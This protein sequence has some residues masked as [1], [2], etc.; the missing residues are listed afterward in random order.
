MN[1][2]SNRLTRITIRFNDSEIIKLE[3]LSKKSN[4]GNADF[5]RN[6]IMTADLNIKDQLSIEILQRIYT[7]LQVLVGTMKDLV[8]GKINQE[9]LNDIIAEAKKR[10]PTS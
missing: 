2:K 4:M 10:Y 3:E 1:D 8:P 7:V 5:I 6:L 9:W